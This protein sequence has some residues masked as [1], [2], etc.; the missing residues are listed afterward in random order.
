MAATNS[1]YDPSAKHKAG[2]ILYETA[3][4][5][6]DSRRNVIAKPS[7]VFELNGSLA[8]E[9]SYILSVYQTLCISFINSRIF[10]LTTVDT[11]NSMTLCPYRSKNN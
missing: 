4:V 1:K 11:T 3:N 5:D 7:G 9:D 10:I 8:E 6:T 2:R